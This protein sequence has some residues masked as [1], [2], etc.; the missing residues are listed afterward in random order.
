M[1]VASGAQQVSALQERT[2]CGHQLA[3]PHVRAG[4]SLDGHLQ[5]SK[6]HVKPDNRAKTAMRW[7]RNGAAGQA[8]AAT[9]CL[10]N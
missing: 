10:R 4:R 2:V 3:Q 5:G 8:C 7:Q 9:T 1:E 6:L